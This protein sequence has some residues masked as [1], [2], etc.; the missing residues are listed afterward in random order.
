MILGGPLPRRR[1]IPTY[2]GNAGSGRATPTLIA[3]HPHV[4]GERFPNTII[5]PVRCGSS[6]RTWGTHRTALITTG[7]DRFIPTYMGN[8]GST[9]THHSTMTVHP[10][11]HGERLIASGR[12]IRTAGSS[13]LTWGTQ[14]RLRNTTRVCLFIPTYMRNAP[15]DGEIV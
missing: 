7:G 10:H 8:A 15:V 13:P 9:Q 11:V 2:M 4:H 12:R 6:P 1:F 3:V 5:K 14:I